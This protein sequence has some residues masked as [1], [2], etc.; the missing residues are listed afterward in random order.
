MMAKNWLV[1]RLNAQ[2]L[3]IIL[4]VF[5]VLGRAYAVELVGTPVPM[6]S[7]SQAAITH[8]EIGDPQPLAPLA[9]L[10]TNSENF[11]ALNKQIESGM[12]AT[13]IKLIVI[14]C[15]GGPVLLIIMLVAMHYRAK[16]RHAK[17]INANIERLLAA[18]RDI[19]IELLR[20]DD[21]ITGADMEQQRR[22]ANLHKGISNICIGVGI[23]I[24]LTIIFSIEFGAIGFILVSIG[25]SRLWIWRLS[26]RKV[27]AAKDHSQNLA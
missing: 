7:S 9:S 2:V 14:F 10:P 8:T 1:G 17:N 15:V 4:L 22:D 12:D 25:V 20:G 3:L 18:G 27:D 23:F 6:N 11:G 13:V 5:S 16:D 19:P 21:A 24:C 26:N